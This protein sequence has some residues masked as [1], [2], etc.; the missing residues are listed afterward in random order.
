MF[1]RVIDRSHRNEV[2]SALNRCTEVATLN[3]ANA[4]KCLFAPPV[5][6]RQELLAFLRRCN[7]NYHHHNYQ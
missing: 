5:V 2:I 4:P 3:L 7:A 6:P 1:M